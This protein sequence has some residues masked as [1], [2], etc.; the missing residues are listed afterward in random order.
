MATINI[1][2]RRLY[3]SMGCS[4]ANQ[5]QLRVAFSFGDHF[6][7]EIYQ[8]NKPKLGIWTETDHE[9]YAI[10][11]Q[12]IT[13]GHYAYHGDAT[14][15]AYP[16]T[17]FTEIICSQAEEVSDEL[18]DAF[19]SD[20][21]AAHQELIKKAEFHAEEY[22]TVLDLLSGVLG[23]RFHPQ[24][25][26]K[27]LNDGS[28]AFH[29]EKHVVNQAGSAIRMLEPIQLN[30]TGTT[31]ISQLFPAIGKIGTGEAEKAS[32]ILGWL[33]RAWAERDIISKFN[34]LFIPLEMILEGVEGE[35]PEEQIKLV[36]KLYSL[37]ATCDEEENEKNA[38]KKL[39]ERL[40]K[41]QRPSLR[42]RFTMFAR[43]ANMPA[44]EN[45]IKVF[46]R[47]NGIRNGLL[48][49]GD[50]NVRIHV[51][52]GEGEVHALEDL[53]ERYINYYLFKDTNVYQSSYSHRPNASV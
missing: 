38:L 5:E 24:F 34:A 21:P 30:D 1:G 25:I 20:D 31:V 22:K 40:V 49:R 11:G 2:Y 3:D 8:G 43:E 17:F 36:E 50:P 47:F 23:L 12:L 10:P 51:T 37:I 35:M 33:I 14:Q 6:Q 18:F 53:T 52:I 16:R 45:D 15:S 41:N 13:I 39:F 26:M 7:V 27:Q 48:H 42:D 4:I 29:G 46:T 9:D 44:Y 19:Y 32:Q 28:V